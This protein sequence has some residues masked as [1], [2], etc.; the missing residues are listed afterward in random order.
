MWINCNILSNNIILH[1]KLKEFINKTPFLKLSE[2]EKS[3]ETGQIIFWDIDSVNKDQE[4]LTSCMDNGG[5]VLVISSFLSDNIISRNF[6]GN[7]I[8][9][10]GTLTKNMTHQQFVEAISN[11]TD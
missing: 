4:Y 8:T 1:Y 3:N 7:E 2:D 10:V 6:S 11:L 9:K 5:I